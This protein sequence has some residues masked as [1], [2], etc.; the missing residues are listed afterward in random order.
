MSG[1][2]KPELFDIWGDGFVKVFV[3]FSD[4]VTTEFLERWS[5]K[6]NKRIAITREFVQAF[7]YLGKSK[8]DINKLFEV[9]D[10]K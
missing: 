2:K 8:A 10:D 4:R 6:L 5:G 9:Q 1:N 7:K 3:I